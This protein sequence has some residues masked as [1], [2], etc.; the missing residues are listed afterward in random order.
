M[1]KNEEIIYFFLVG[2]PK[3]FSFFFKKKEEEKGGSAL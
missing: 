3:V 1:C 2:R